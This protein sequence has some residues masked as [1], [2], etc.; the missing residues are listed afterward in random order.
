MPPIRCSPLNSLPF[1]SQWIVGVG[2]P[3]AAQRN[4]T[5]LAAGTARSFL[6]IRSGLVQYGAS[7]WGTHN[8]GLE[9]VMESSETKLNL[10]H[11]NSNMEPLKTNQLSS[12]S[13]AM[14]QVCVKSL[15]V[16]LKSFNQLSQIKIRSLHLIQ[17]FQDKVSG[18]VLRRVNQVSI[19]IQV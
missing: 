13:Q 18:Q 7:V 15:K 8:K 14:N 11:S 1:F 16:S 6:S 9:S 4:L 5:V 2:F 19:A 10:K 12:F 17:I 3:A